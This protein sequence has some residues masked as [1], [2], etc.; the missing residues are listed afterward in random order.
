M[1]KSKQ[2]KKPVDI[3][4]II[5]L[6]AEANVTYYQIEKDLKIGKAIV[7]RGVKENTERPIPQ[8]WE[9]PILKY[10]RK[11]I[12]E[13]NEV[14]LQTIEV[15]E[16]LGFKIPDKESGLIESEKAVK[17]EWFGKLQK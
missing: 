2:K 12:Q 6:I 14:E 17:Q 8:K 1:V 5:S 7:S 3:E 9:L 10:L 11:K 4:K 13:K 16:E 15:L